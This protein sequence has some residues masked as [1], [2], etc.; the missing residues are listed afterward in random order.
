MGR[1]ALWRHCG[2][3][4]EDEPGLGNVHM[5]KNGDMAWL[6]FTLTVQTGG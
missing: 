2:G 3:N 4:P 1:N 6:D 5:A